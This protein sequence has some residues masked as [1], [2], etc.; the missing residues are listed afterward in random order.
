[1]KLRNLISKTR[2][3]VDKLYSYYVPPFKIKVVLLTE[4]ELQGVIEDLKKHGG[5]AGWMRLDAT[6]TQQTSIHLRRS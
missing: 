4:N 3:L 6:I 2:T 5:L 1:L